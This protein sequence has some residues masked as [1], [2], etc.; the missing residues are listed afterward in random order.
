M[1]ERGKAGRPPG[2]DKEAVTVRLPVDL[3]ERIRKLAEDN[4][5]LLS[6]EIQ[7]APHGCEPCGQPHR[8]A[9][10]PVASAA[11]VRSS[12]SPRP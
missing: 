6:A 5:R 3:M 10:S 1:D 7:V 9:V 8:R 11:A 4:R 2:E 12:S